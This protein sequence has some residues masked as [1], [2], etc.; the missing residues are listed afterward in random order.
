[1]DA[2]AALGPALFMVQGLNY[3]ELERSFHYR[4]V[5]VDR[6]GVRPQRQWLGPGAENL[7]LHGFIYPGDPRF[8][9][10]L[11]T[12]DDLRRQSA[13]GQFFDFAVMSNAFSARYLGTWCVLSIQDEHKVFAPNGV[14]RKVHFT[15]NLSAFGGNNAV[16]AGQF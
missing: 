11:E 15:V 14:P 1:M 4:W 8:T 6:L 9:G 3:Q 7:T 16:S 10:A 5:S 2:L 12:L 13:Q